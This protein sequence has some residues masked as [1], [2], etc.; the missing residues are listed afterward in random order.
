MPRETFKD[1][2]NC[3]VLSKVEYGNLVYGNASKGVLDIVQKIENAAVKTITKSRKFDRVT[4]LLEE[5]NWLRMSDRCYL[6][7]CTLLYKCLN[8]IGQT[9]LSDK[10]IPLTNTHNY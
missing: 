10:L 8:G 2:V 3:V 4:P 7:R 5:L 1:L 6:Q 9:Y